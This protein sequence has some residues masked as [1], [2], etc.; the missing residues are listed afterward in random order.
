MLLNRTLA[1]GTVALLLLSLAAPP[2][3]AGE[4]PSWLPR[5]R[6]TVELDPAACTARVHLAATWTNRHRTPAKELVFNAYGNYVVPSK[7]VG[8]MAKTLEILRVN[9][10]EALGVKEPALVL[11]RVS[12]PDAPAPGQE[13]PLTF[14]F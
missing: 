3:G 11:H 10:G 12:L 2:A 6:G 9:P 4:P 5:Y 13:A 14:R 8:L 7:D 1:L